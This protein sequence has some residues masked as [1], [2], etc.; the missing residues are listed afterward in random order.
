MALT[1][2][3][4]TAINELAEGINT[5]AENLDGVLDAAEETKAQLQDTLNSLSALQIEEAREQQLR[6]SLEA[7]IAQ[8][9]QDVVGAL[10]PLTNQ[11]AAMNSSLQTAENEGGSPIT[12]GEPAEPTPDPGAPTEPPSA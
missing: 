11:I 1:A 8:L 10:Q 4:Q 7:A 2:A 12:P 5:L 3:Q 9:D 6:E